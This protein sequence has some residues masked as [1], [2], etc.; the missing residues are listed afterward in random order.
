MG[1]FTFKKRYNCI[2]VLPRFML[3][4]M[5][6]SKISLWFIYLFRKCIFL[7][8]DLLEVVLLSKSRN[9]LALNVRARAANELQHCSTY[10]SLWRTYMIHLPFTFYLFNPTTPTSDVLSIKAGFNYIRVR[11]LAKKYFYAIG[12]NV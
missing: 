12:W 1:V 4:S 8:C 2:F 3:L 7:Y 10:R 11:V 9:V 5:I 6:V